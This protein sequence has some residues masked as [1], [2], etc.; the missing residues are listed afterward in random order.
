M[1]KRSARQLTENSNQWRMV[2]WREQMTGN[3]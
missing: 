3:F 2:G 1:L